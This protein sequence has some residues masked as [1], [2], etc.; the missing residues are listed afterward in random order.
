MASAEY[1]FGIFV[2]FIQDEKAQEMYED[3]KSN[4]GAG[5]E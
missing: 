1:F 2:N 4:V 3:A 5:N